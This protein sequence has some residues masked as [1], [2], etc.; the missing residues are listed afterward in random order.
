MLA[1][2]AVLIF[3]ASTSGDKVPKMWGSRVVGK[4]SGPSDTMYYEYND[5]FET[6]LVND[7]V[8]GVMTIEGGRCV[9]SGRYHWGSPCSRG[10][11]YANITMQNVTAQKVM[12]MDEDTLRPRV[13]S[14]T[15]F[16][17]RCNFTRPPAGEVDVWTSFPLSRFVKDMPSFTIEFAVRGA[18][19]NSAVNQHTLS[20]SVDSDNLP[21]RRRNAFVNH[22]N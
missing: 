3:V 10:A 22:M 21:S 12:E 14:T 19:Y 4:P 20:G 15:F 13:A 17:P 8:L 11:N 16:V 6:V 18:N 9:L 2:T 7:S 5:K 1:I